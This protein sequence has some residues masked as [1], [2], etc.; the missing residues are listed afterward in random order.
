MMSDGLPGN[1]TGVDPGDNQVAPPMFYLNLAGAM[2]GILDFTQVE[3][4]K[5]FHKAT[6]KLDNEELYECTPGNMF[7]FLKLLKQ[8]TNEHGWDDKE[9]GVLW[10]PEDHNDPASAFVQGILG[11]IRQDIRKIHRWKE[12]EI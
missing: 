6:T 10:V 9:T 4:R 7:H 11:G 3:K 8:R 12:R 1:A 2:T 5:Y